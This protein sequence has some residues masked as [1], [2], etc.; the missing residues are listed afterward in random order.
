[1]QHLAVQEV[2]QP[3]I[4]NADLAAPPAMVGLKRLCPIMTGVTC[5][6]DG[7]CDS[8]DFCNHPEINKCANT[9]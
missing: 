8:P 4:E 1:M 5:T 2:S 3:Q 6:Q 9:V 7:G